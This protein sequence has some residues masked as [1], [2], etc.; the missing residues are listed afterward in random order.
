MY[1]FSRKVKM[2]VDQKELMTFWKLSGTH[3]KYFI[4]FLYSPPVN[5]NHHLHHHRRF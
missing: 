5:I 3:C 4:E 1:G 2:Y